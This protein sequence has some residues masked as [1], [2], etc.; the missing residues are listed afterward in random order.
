MTCIGAEPSICGDVR[1]K[2]GGGEGRDTGCP[3]QAARQSRAAMTLVAYTLI[4]GG[5]GGGSKGGDG[6][7]G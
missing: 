5:K 7:E 2:G 4:E 6:D 1:G 3:A